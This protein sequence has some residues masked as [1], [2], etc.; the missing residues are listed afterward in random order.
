MT[1]SRRQTTS[2]RRR[3]RSP[4]RRALVAPSPAATDSR[5]R[6]DSCR[7]HHHGRRHDDHL[8]QRRRRR[9]PAQRH[10]T[11]RS[12]GTLL[13]ARSTASPA[14]RRIHRRHRRRDHAAHGHD[15]RI[16]RLPARHRRRFAALGFASGGRHGGAPD[17]RRHAR[18]R[19]RDR[20]RPATFLNEIHQRRRGDRLRLDGNAGQPAIAMGQDRQRRARRPTPTPGT[21]ST[22]AN[23]NATGTQAAWVNAGTNFTFSANGNLI[24]PARSAHHDSRTSPSAISRS[25]TW[26]SASAPAR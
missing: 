2:W 1:G 3:R 23:P 22:R 5:R 12:V 7:R 14:T 15:A 6:R 9:Q 24:S 8:R 10:S 18:H 17:R 21:C 16:S 13:K 19:H 26:R 25:E 11:Q 20:Q 4:A